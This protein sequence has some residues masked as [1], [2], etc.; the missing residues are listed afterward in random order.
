[1]LSNVLGEP[2]AL[3][4]E[5]LKRSPNRVWLASNHA[6]AAHDEVT[7][8]QCAACDQ[9]VLEADRIDDLMRA[10]WA[11]HGLKTRTILRSSSLEA[12]RSLVGA[13]L[14]I[15]VLPDFLYRA[16]TLDAEH[17]DA[18]PLRDAVPT[19][20]VGLVW[21]RGSGLKPVA[22]EFIEQAREQSRVRRA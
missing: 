17:I 10:V 3:V 11:R 7:L 8:A 16:W 19:V 4:T 12:V 1:M 5:T 2:Q 13:G 6:L 22:A 15:T 14:G 9:V 20:D 21:R 18:R